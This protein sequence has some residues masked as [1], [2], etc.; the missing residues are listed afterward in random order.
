MPVKRCPTCNKTFDD[1]HLS[2]CV[3]D[4]TPLADF[5]PQADETTVV[6]SSAGSDATNE[7]ERVGPGEGSSEGSSEREV[8]RYQAPGSYLPPGAAAQSRQRTWPLVLGILALVLV[9]FAGLGIA[10][11]ILIPRMVRQSVN[12]NARN[13][14][15]RVVTVDNDNTNAK[16]S[17]ADENHNDNSGADNLLPPTNEQEVLSDLKNTEDEWTA[18]NINADKKKLNRILADDY[19]DTFEGKPRGKAEYLRTAERDTT[20]Q[21]WAFEDLRI[22]LKGDRATLSGI[23]RFEIKDQQ[24]QDREVPVTFVDKFVWRDGRWQATGSEVSPLKE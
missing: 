10:A 14:N 2:F 15:D 17:T 24:G 20:T 3:D 12:A 6:R 22:T 1:Q 5:D 18:A 9:V 8:P 16:T 21:K 11:V 7:T 4:G 13:S 19:V 23:V